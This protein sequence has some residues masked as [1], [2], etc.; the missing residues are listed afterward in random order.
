MKMMMEMNEMTFS[1]CYN[2]IDCP[3]TLRE[4]ARQIRA[5]AAFAHGQT[6]QDALSRATYLDLRADEIERMSSDAERSGIS[7]D[8]GSII[9]ADCNWDSDCGSSDSDC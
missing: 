6:Y 3:D 1:N 2:S 5:N 9:N 8:R 4:A 7:V